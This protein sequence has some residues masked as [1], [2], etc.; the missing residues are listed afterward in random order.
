MSARPAA[1][2]TVPVSGM[3]C[4]ACEKRVGKALRA[5][6]GV[7]AVSVSAAR[8]VATL[9]GPDL[10]DRDRVEAAIRSPGW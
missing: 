4:D 6:D 1:T 7:D 2:L 5:L 10:P 3:T 9:R 8:G